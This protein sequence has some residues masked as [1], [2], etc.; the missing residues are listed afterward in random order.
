MGLLKLITEKQLNSL[1]DSENAALH[2]SLS[3]FLRVNTAAWCL[4][5]QTR[6]T[7]TAHTSN[8]ILLQMRSML[9]SL[10]VVE[11]L[12]SNNILICLSHNSDYELIAFHLAKVFS[13]KIIA[14]FESDSAKKIIDNIKSL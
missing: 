4:M 9:S 7:Q 13:L 12:P 3:E 5:F 2:K 10:G 11:M 14:S 8:S 1:A 6:D